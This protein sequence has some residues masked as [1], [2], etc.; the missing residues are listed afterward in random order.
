MMDSL[1]ERWR[2]WRLA[3][4]G[5]VARHPGPLD[6]WVLLSQVREKL[7][8][9]G[10]R[11]LGLTADNLTSWLDESTR[12]LPGFDAERCFAEVFSG[13]GE[14]S[15]GEPAGTIVD[16]RGVTTF[17]RRGPRSILIRNLSNAEAE[18]FLATRLEA[19]GVAKNGQAYLR[20]R[21]AETEEQRRI[22]ALEA[23]LNRP[24]TPQEINQRVKP[25]D[26]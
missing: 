2:R 10:V 6:P 3:R 18:N 7:F 9:S 13:F 8:E 4:R 17:A 22:Q 24:L 21:R 25:P 14:Q 16:G 20:K 23:D 19:A 5:F 11:Q 1:R 26:F 15:E 12:A